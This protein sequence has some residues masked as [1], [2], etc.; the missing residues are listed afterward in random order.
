M[1]AHE[2]DDTYLLRYDIRNLIL[3]VSH[4]SNVYND[5]HG[6][7]ISSGHFYGNSGHQKQRCNREKWWEH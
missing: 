7:D 2:I 4:D 1:F 6:T 3:Y 5:N